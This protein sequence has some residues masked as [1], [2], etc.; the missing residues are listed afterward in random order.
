MHMTIFFV[1]L[2]SMIYIHHHYFSVFRQ[3]KIK[4]VIIEK[5]SLVQWD[6]LFVV[7]MDKLWFIMS[8]IKFFPDIFHNNIWQYIQFDKLQF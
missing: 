8:I 5:I 1:F 4:T 2:W 7:D 3:L 6:A